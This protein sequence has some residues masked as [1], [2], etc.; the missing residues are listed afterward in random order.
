MAMA[1][2][3]DVGGWFANAPGILQR[4]GIV[5]LRGDRITT[6]VGH[7]LLAGDAFAQADTAVADLGREFLKRA[8][9]V[10][11]QATEMAVAPD[12]FD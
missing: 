6:P 8:A 11:P 2:S 12:G 10:L 7:L 3:F 4:V 1:P 9:L 5:L